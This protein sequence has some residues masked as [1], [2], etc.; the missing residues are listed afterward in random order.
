MKRWKKKRLYKS[1]FPRWS[2]R[3]LTLSQK[4][5]VWVNYG[6]ICLSIFSDEW[7]D[8]WQIIMIINIYFTTVLKNLGMHTS[9]QRERSLTKMYLKLIF[10][11]SFCIVRNLKFATS[12]IL[13]DSSEVKFKKTLETE[14]C[15]LSKWRW[16]T[17][18]RYSLVS[19]NMNILFLLIT[20]LVFYLYSTGTLRWKLVIIFFLYVEGKIM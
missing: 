15:V 14:K 20:R 8:L 5:T 19:K 3:Q 13:A 9:L 16:L 7:I 6:I 12:K 18:W 2:Q 4:H 10:M 17:G 11:Q 1:Y